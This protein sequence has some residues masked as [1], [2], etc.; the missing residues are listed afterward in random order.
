LRSR[1][2]A[3]WQNSSSG[4]LREPL[5]RRRQ[6]KPPLHGCQPVSLRRLRGDRGSAVAL[7][8]RVS[9]ASSSAFRSVA[10]TR[11]YVG[12]PQATVIARPR[13]LSSRDFQ[14]WKTLRNKRIVSAN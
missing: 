4:I 11:V 7:T 14:S 8:A 12:T 9:V 1:R 3:H 6:E 10:V 2:H 5:L 13:R